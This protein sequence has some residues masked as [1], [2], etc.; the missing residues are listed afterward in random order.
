ME[1][2]KRFSVIFFD[3][4]GLL[5]DTEPLHFEAYVAMLEGRGYTLDW[6]FAHYVSIAHFSSIGLEHEIY[7]SFPKLKEEEPNWAVLYKEKKRELEKIFARGSF[8][9]M[10][11]VERLLEA[12][13]LYSVTTCVVTNSTKSQTETVK[14]ALP[15]LRNLPLW[16][17]REDYVHPKPSPDSYRA[18]LK[19]VGASPE[20]V[21]GFE[22]TVRG[23]RA[24]HEAG[25]KGILICPPDHPQRSDPLAQ[26][27]PYF[28]SFSAMET[29][30]AEPV[31]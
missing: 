22:D 11:G 24:L 16:I 12:L 6:D 3:F 31:A 21:I 25:I 13:P 2:L 5:V 26:I 9:L 17:T 10:P 29:D 18:A 15:L 27:A 14:E 30:S 20:E 19:R 28:P 23:L 7:R 8:A 4:D 1:W